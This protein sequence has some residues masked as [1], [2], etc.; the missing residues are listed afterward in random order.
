MAS[1]GPISRSRPLFLPRNGAIRRSAVV[2]DGL[3]LTTATDRHQRQI[4]GVRDAA[5]GVN[6]IPSTQLAPLIAQREQRAFGAQVS[7]T[8]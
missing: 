2:P 6:D 5:N 4:H 3:D 7:A 8:R 1:W